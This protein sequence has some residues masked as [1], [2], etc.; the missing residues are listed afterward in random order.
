M[1]YSYYQGTMYSLDM[2]LKANGSSEAVPW[3]LVQKPDLTATDEGVQGAPLDGYQP[4]MALAQNHV[5]FMG[6]PGFKAGDVK[7]FVIHYSY[8]QPLP[9]SYGSFA[10]T[11]GKTASFFKDIG[12]QTRFAYI[13]DDGKNTYVVDVISNSTATFPAPPSLDPYAEYAASPSALVRLSS[14]S[15][16]L[17]WM[18]YDNS[19]SAAS[20]ATW[21]SITLTGVEVASPASAAAGPKNNNG[22]SKSGA[23]GAT[24]TDHDSG[25][26][27]LQVW[28][29][30]LMGLVG[31][32]GAVGLAL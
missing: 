9:Q 13:P 7:V 3:N 6:V 14:D 25:A 26:V 28:N 5:H 27:G 18:N 2:A 15:G 31:V 22:T 20:R 8:M 29:A 12:V 24:E 4:T 23:K 21:R 11:H 30:L 19:S 1:F 10:T 16:K 32:V 17:S